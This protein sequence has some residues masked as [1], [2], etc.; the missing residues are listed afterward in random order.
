MKKKNKPNNIYIHN[1][2]AHMAQH[3]VAGEYLTV[4]ARQ[5]QPECKTMNKLARYE[6][7]VKLKH[8]A[9]FHYMHGF[10]YGDG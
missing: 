6:N 2:L 9:F 8:L 10:G 5:M 1:S 3:G 7:H 4:W